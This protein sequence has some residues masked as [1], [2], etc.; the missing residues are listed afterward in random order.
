MSLCEPEC[1]YIGYDSETK[2][3][4]CECE[5]KEEISIFNIKIDTKRLL[6]KFSGLT[7]SNIDIIKCYYLI[8]KKENLIYNI[9]FY[10][11]LFIII[12]FCIDT[13]IFIFKGYNLLVKKIDIIIIYILND[14]S[15][16]IKNIF[17]K[18][19]EKIHKRS[20]KNN[21]PPIKKLKISK[22]KERNNRLD[23]SNEGISIHKLKSKNNESI[24]NNI[25]NEQEKISK[26]IKIKKSII[27]NTINKNNL[28]A[29]I[30]Y[31]KINSVN[32]SKEYLDEY[33]LNHL[34]FK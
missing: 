17:N 3:S 8:F 24:A 34:K 20:L 9:G 27:I 29:D 33:E 1:D 10:V 19:K 14:S 2:N 18:R 28:I 25:N 21:N 16:K 22:R 30:P 7:I 15:L 6:K 13:I 12:L 11:I 32:N 26:D 5:I 23:I 31:S 4:K